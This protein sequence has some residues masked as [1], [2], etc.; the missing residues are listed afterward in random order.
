LPKVV[1]CGSRNDAFK[2]F[3]TALKKAKPNEK[4]WVT[5]KNPM[6]RKSEGR[7]YKK[8]HVTC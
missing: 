3:K 4:M 8:Q 7:G 6:G 2:D 5:S 1:A